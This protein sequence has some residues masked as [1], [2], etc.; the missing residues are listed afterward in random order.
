M[1]GGVGTAETTIL[2]NAMLAIGATN[3]IDDSRMDMKYSTDGGNENRPIN[4]AVY[5]IIKVK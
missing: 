3:V 1:A 5:Y 2:S 4:A